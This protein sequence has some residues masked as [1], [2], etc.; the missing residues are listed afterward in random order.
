ML[1]GGQ[2]IGQNGLFID[3]FQALRFLVELRFQV[4]IR[5]TLIAAGLSGVETP[6]EETDDARDNHQIPQSEARPHAGYKGD[7]E[8]VLFRAFHW[9]ISLS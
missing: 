4:A 1:R 6:A 7:M 8:A 3:A 9:S 2:L 5:G